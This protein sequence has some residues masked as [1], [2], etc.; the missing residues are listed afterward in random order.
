MRAGHPHIHAHA[1]A[2]CARARL[3]RLRGPG[4]GTRRASH[5]K[6][7]LGAKATSGDHT[8]TCRR[9]GPQHMASCRP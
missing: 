7:H 4:T 5:R 6:C 3:L 2:V 9:E 8:W 1:V